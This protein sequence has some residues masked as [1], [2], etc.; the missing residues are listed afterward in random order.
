MQYLAPASAANGSKRERRKG[1]RVCEVVSWDLRGG[2]MPALAQ[3]AG[4][5]PVDQA[6]HLRPI[7]AWNDFVFTPVAQTLWSTEV[8]G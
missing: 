3:L 4:D 8:P 2:P 1:Y 6:E 7:S 5:L